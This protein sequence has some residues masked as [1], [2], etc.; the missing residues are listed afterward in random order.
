[1]LKGCEIGMELLKKRDVKKRNV[2]KWSGVSKGV[3]DDE[4]QKGSTVEVEACTERGG[5]AKRYRQ[6]REYLQR[7]RSGRYQ[8]HRRTRKVMCS[9]LGTEEREEERNCGW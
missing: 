4:K 7:I 5:L 2:R 1:M 6:R 8:D 9:M 3:G